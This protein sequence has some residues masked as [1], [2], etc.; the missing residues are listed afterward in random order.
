MEL[1]DTNDKK[2]RYR[3]K[4]LDLDGEQL[5]IDFPVEDESKKAKYFLLGTEFRVWFLG[6]DQAIYLFNSEIEGK[7]ERK[8]GL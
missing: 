2:K 8:S 3:S 1:N 6:T 7:V 4:L 5:F